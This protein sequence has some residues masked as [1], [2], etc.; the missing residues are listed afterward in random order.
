MRI[1]GVI[2]DTKEMIE[3]M[4]LL[5]PY[6]LRIRE[7][8]RRIEGGRTMKIVIWYRGLLLGEPGGLAYSL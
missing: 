7:V 6:P 2:T 1:D 5:H 4:M 8:K 3:V